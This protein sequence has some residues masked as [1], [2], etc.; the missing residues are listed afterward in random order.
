VTVYRWLRSQGVA[1]SQIVMM[2]GSAGAHLTL[3]TAV[4]LRESGDALPAALVA[5]S[6]PTDMAMTGETFRTKALVD[7][8][9]GWGLAKNAFAA[10][11]R[12]GAIDV[13]N[14]LVS[15]LYADVHGFPPTF[16]QVGTQEI[17]LSDSIRMVQK[18]KATGVEVKLEVWPGM[19]HGWQSI[20]FIPEAQLAKAHKVKFI[21]RHLGA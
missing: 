1:A 12:N 16:L 14:P 9:L 6:P 2:G 21:R 17:L 4:A 19:F 10:Y 7:P 3:T 15:P 20:N 18:M 8:I 13:R 11:T 5:E